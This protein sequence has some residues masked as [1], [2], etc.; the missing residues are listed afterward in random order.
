MSGCQF[1]YLLIDFKLSSALA[2]IFSSVLQYLKW[3]KWLVNTYLKLS[4]NLPVLKP[5][6]LDTLREKKGS[7]HEILKIKKG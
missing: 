7:E 5:I 6:I 4:T 3:Q 2:V 1:E